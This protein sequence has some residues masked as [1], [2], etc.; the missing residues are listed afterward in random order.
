LA[1]LIRERL[2]FVNLPGKVRRSEVRELPAAGSTRRPQ[3]EKWYSNHQLAGI[4][5]GPALAK[6]GGWDGSGKVVPRRPRAPESG[7]CREAKGF[8]GVITGMDGDERRAT[9][10]RNG[11]T[12][13]NGNLTPPGPG[14]ILKCIEGRTRDIDR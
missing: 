1:R 11:R 14:R 6:T 9:I 4:H 10:N 3:I 5:E 7:H 8:R 12:L 2:V 13:A